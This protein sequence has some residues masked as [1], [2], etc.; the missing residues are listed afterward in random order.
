MQKKIIKI[1]LMHIV[2]LTAL[3]LFVMFVPCPL[4]ALFNIPCPLCGITRAIT[5]FF[6]GKFEI[7]W[8]LHPL[9]WLFPIAFLFLC[10]SRLILKKT[11]KKYII[12]IL[13]AI[14]GIAFIVTYFVRDKS[15]LYTYP[16]PF[17]R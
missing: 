12:Y 13:I 3:A 14:I 8:Q 4:F 5:A 16:Q 1:I 10:H 6:Q 7:A 15:I 2:M 17:F 11:S 9:F